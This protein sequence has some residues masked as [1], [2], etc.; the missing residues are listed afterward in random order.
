MQ[1]RFIYFSILFL[2]SQTLS[3]QLIKETDYSNW[4]TRV[5]SQVRSDVSFGLDQRDLDR[6][7]SNF[8]RMPIPSDSSDIIF[9]FQSLTHLMDEFYAFDIS[10]DESAAFR[11]LVRVSPNRIVSSS[12]TGE[13]EFLKFYESLLKNFQSF[14]ISESELIVLI[15]ATKLIP[16]NFSDYESLSNLLDFYLPGY[17]YDGVRNHIIYEIKNYSNDFVD[18]NIYARKVSVKV[19]ALEKLR[20]MILTRENEKALQTIDEWIL[21][22]RHPNQ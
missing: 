21:E 10:E 9:Y 18:S 5:I 19:S 17:K 14:D 22:E 12:K 11:L 13:T 15:D 8:D 16:N 7:Y 2:F 4:L 20:I 1:M 3:A 6:F